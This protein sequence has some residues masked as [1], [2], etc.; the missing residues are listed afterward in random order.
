MRISLSLTDNEIAVLQGLALA[1]PVVIAAIPLG[2]MID[3]YTRVRLIL[4][5]VALSCVGSLFTAMASSFVTLFAA[6]SVVGLSRAATTVAV[7]SLLA[8][9]Y[10]PVQRGRAKAVIGIGQ[11]AGASAAFALGGL[12]LGIFTSGEGWH[13][14]MVWLTCPLLVL[15]GVAM[16]ALREPP[17][18]GRMIQK[19]SSRE[20][21]LELWRYR[22]M[23]GPLVGGIVMA[24]VGVFAVLTWAGPALSRSFAIAPVRMGAIMG[25]TTLASGLV[26]PMMGGA[27][28]DLCQRTGGPRRTAV[29]LSVLAFSSACVGSFACAPSIAWASG[30]LMAFVAVVG[31]MVSMGTT[32]FTIVIPNE[33]RGLCLAIL[34]AFAALFGLGLGPVAVSLLAGAIGGPTMIG[35]SLAA[36]CVFSSVLCVAMFALAA[37]TVSRAV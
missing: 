16:L 4:V 24:E 15:V 23:V 14:A 6:R 10:P 27:L 13:W 1:L 19:P 8:D 22:E 3:R 9:L 30:L 33:L 2:F 28:A 5:F 18:S 7:F 20:T 25:M 31:A 12:L 36:V 21:L 17:R 37:R 26:G 29:V 32:L 11:Y 35:T 34:A